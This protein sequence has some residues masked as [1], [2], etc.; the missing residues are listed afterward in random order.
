MKVTRII[1]T[2][3]VMSAVLAGTAQAQGPAT[4]TVNCTGTTSARWT[5]PCQIANTVSAAV[6][7]V[8][9]MELTAAT[10]LPAPIAE[11]FGVATG[12]STTTPTVLTVRANAGYKVTASAAAATWTGP[13][14][15][16]KA[17]SDLRLTTDGFAN[18]RT[19]TQTGVDIFT[20]SAPTAGTNIDIG[21]NVLYNWTTD[22]PGNYQL[23]I[24]YTL[25]AP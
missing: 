10:T 8:A 12:K 19:L 23:A 24:N 18:L 11:D 21:Y 1:A 5:T 16:N 3:A 14:G 22:V 7:F 2:A 9:R 15:S 6:P 13:T 4:P 25:T 17:V 20:A